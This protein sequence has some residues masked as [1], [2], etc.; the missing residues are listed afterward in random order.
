MHPV[1]LFAIFL[2]AILMVS[3]SCRAPQGT[4]AHDKHLQVF[5]D[6]VLGPGN[7]IHLNESR[8][9]ALCQQGPAGDHA[10]RKYRYIVVRLPDHAVLLQGNFQMG[11]VKWAD[12]QSIA[13][14]SG[15]TSGKDGSTEEIIQ[16]T[17]PTE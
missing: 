14:I 12:D 13:V 4:G 15:S 8:N 2:I 3:G 17:S 7:T 5:A 11:S 6:S 9:M 1:N 16:V 10:M